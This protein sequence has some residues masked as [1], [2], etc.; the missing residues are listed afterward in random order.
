MKI[1]NKRINLLDLLIIVVLPIMFGNLL[2]ISPFYGEVNFIDEGQFLAWVNH[3]LNG[4]LMFRDIYITYGPL[5]VYP[6]Y[7]LFKV[8]G[9]SVFILRI[10]FIV[11]GAIAS[12]L[13]IRPVAK[14]LGLEKKL[15]L[16]FTL[17][18]LLLP[19]LTVRHSLP[20]LAIYLLFKSRTTN[21]LVYSLW[22]GI[23]SA[24]TFLVSQEIGAFVIFGLLAYYFIEGIFVRNISIF[25]KGVFALI[26][27]MLSLFTVFSIWAYMEGWLASY[28]ETAF[29]VLQIFSG[30]SIPNG[31]AMVS[32]LE[33]ISK[34]GFVQ[35][36][37]S[38]EMLFLIQGLILICGLLYVVYKSLIGKFNSRTLVLLSVLL[39]GFYLYISVIGRSGN[40]FLLLVPTVTICFYFIKFLTRNLR[41]TKSKLRIPS[42]VI[43]ILIVAFFIRIVAIYRPHF[44]KFPL[45]VE[46]VLNSKNIPLFGRVSV[47]DSQLSY[48]KE[49][50]YY[51]QKNTGKNDYIF[52]LSNEPAMYFFADRLNPTRY[53]LPYI[54]IT[55]E[56]RYEVLKDIREKKPKLIFFNNESWPVDGISNKQRLPE[57]LDFIERHYSKKTILNGAVEVYTLNS[58][59]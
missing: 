14:I 42:I 30:T 59:I 23:V 18:I 11:I 46:A 12:V 39:Y 15:L 8:F 32:P 36:I 5:Y 25:L 43:I 10:Y 56:K 28:V 55:I 17:F 34:I 6:L 44:T 51:I 21:K 53:D 47:P 57:V 37:V 33:V 13:M 48:V 52:F 22:L 24:F 7:V 26:C 1:L 54:P 9:S 29:D 20:F 58:T 31:M 40:F 4:K 35:Y 3:M 45:S 50:D 49:I 27:G 16:V 2:F 19:G 41:L 38:K